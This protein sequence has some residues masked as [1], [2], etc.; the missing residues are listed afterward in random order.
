MK[1]KI[2]LMMMALLLVV[3]GVWMQ[4]KPTLSGRKY[5]ISKD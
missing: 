1:A 5:G 4:A 2:F 3:A